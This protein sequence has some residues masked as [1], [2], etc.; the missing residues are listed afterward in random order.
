MC[1]IMKNEIKKNNNNNKKKNN[2]N[3][4]KTNFF[5]TCLRQWTTILFIFSEERNNYIFLNHPTKP[6]FSK[7]FLNLLNKLQTLVLICLFQKFLQANIVLQLDFID[8]NFLIKGVQ[9]L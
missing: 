7:I 3:K 8:S 5:E 4:W 9:F 6:G 1:F 2:N